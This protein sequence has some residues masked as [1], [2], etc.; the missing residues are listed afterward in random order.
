MLRADAALLS[1]YGLNHIQVM[2]SGQ[3][4]AKNQMKRLDWA[5]PITMEQ[6]LKNYKL[7]SEILAIRKAGGQNKTKGKQ[8][9][10]QDHRG[11]TNQRVSISEQIIGVI[12]SLTF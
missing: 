8:I 1:Q 7:E 9:V 6:A 3:P 2:K 12:G 4:R 10:Q 11:P 5:D